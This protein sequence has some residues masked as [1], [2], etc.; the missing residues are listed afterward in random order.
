MRKAFTALSVTG[1]LET[2][3]LSYLKLYTP[4]GISDL[5]SATGSG[6]CT[7][8]L[9]SPYATVNMNGL[10]IPLTV[11]GSLAYGIVALLSVQPLVLDSEK[12]H[13][14]NNRLV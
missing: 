3:Y 14:T 2:G 7:S 9:N 13:E 8:V 12:F 4:S 5:C 11:V 6:S 10:E 1:M